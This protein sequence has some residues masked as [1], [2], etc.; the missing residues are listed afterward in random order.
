MNYGKAVKTLRAARQLEQRDLAAH[1]GLDSSYI[2]L[3]EA[4]KRVPS[5]AALSAIAEALRVPMYLLMI[6]ASEKDDL[7][8]VPEEVATHIGSTL[9]GVVLATNGDVQD[10]R[11]ISKKSSIRARGRKTSPGI[12]PRKKPTRS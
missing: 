3:I 10:V 6:L 12:T 11:P 9:L 1:A 8:G 2:S 7:H 5:T 4:Q